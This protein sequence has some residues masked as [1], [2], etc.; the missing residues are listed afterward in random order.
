MWLYWPLLGQINE[1][2]KFTKTYALFVV[3]SLLIFQTK[4]KL[5]FVLSIRPGY[6]L[7]VFKE[8]N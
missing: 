5:I 2:A 7:Q 3:L 4:H 1:I 8:S 6:N